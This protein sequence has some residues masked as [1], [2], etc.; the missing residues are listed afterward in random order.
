M[1]NNSTPTANSSLNPHYFLWLSD[2]HY[3]P[4]YG[5]SRAYTNQYSPVSCGAADG[6]DDAPP[7]GKHGCDSPQSLIRSTLDRAARAMDEV[8]GSGSDQS[9]SF[10]LITGDCLRHG[11]DELFS[12]SEDRQN[13]SLTADGTAT[14]A[15]EAMK[16]GGAAI[17]R[18]LTVIVQEYFPNTQIVFSIGNNDVVPDY[19]LNFLDTDSAE[20]V[21][22]NAGSSAE[23]FASSASS[24]STNEESTGMLDLIYQALNAD[25]YN[26]DSFANTLQT[27][28]LKPTD[29]HTFLKGGY[30]YR[31]F[32]NGGLL[33]L[34]LN[35]VIYSPFYESS[36]DDKIHDNSTNDNRPDNSDKMHDDDPRGQFTWLKIILSEARRNQSRAVIVGHISPSVGSFRH[37]QLWKTEY[38][39]RYY[40][41]VGQFNDV[42]MGQLF[43]H[44]HT[45]EF[46]L[47]DGADKR[48]MN[49][50]VGNG[51]G[52][53]VAVDTPIL[54]GPSVTPLHGNDPSFRIVKYGHIISNGG[55][56]D[57]QPSHNATIP[58]NRDGYYRLLDYDSYR[59]DIRDGNAS[60]S[61][62]YIF[63]EAYNDVISESFQKEGLSSATFHGI[64]K[65]MRHNNIA[66]R[67]NNEHQDIEDESPTLKTFRY[68]VRSGA[69]GND[70]MTGANSDCN[71]QCQNEWLCTLTSITRDGYDAC[72]SQSSLNNSKAMTNHRNVLGIVA[73]LFFASVVAFMLVIRMVRRRMRRRDYES[74][75]SVHQGDESGIAINVETR[76]GRDCA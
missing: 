50:V 38:I 25:G 26:T 9:P 47:V 5:S 64:V 18:E 34:S 22:D 56:G 54:L 28:V 70:A 51:G 62:L 29:Q 53:I 36:S 61:K 60:W 55:S 40:E 6:D 72:V 65:S 74:T 11:V 35:T 32:H 76:G 73:G 31:S 42:V 68:F 24:M 43:G 19:Y 37:T 7:I 1:T 17:L 58:S 57:T 23:N 15:E 46:R 44:I 69:D 67:S 48:G 66:I 49:D 39:Q 4:H 8:D 33:I 20:A 52:G 45:D 41:I 27:S 75:P 10:I 59:C 3:D 14:T 71:S 21:N 13:D 2:I 12:S 30:Y 16:R 63:S